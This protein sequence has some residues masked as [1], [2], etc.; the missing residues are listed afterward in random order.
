MLRKK[1]AEVSSQ[2]EENQMTRGETIN[3]LQRSLEDSQ[4]QC[5]ALLEKCKQP[6]QIWTHFP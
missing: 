2:L 5:Q 3:R 6:P 4:A 1:L